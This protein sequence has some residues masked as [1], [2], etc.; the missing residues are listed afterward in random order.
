[1]EQPLEP[2][3]R[4]V[5]CKVPACHAGLECIEPLGN[6]GFDFF[7]AGPL[8]LQLNSQQSDVITPQALPLPSLQIGLQCLHVE[9]KGMG[10]VFTQQLQQALE[11]KGP[12]SV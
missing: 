5:I 12:A 11:A 2:N 6:W 1:M 4:E 3:H 8:S 10:T 9:G 7:D